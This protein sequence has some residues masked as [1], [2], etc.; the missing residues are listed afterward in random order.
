MIEDENYL[1][2]EE[3][4]YEMMLQ[5]E[6]NQINEEDMIAIRGSEDRTYSPFVTEENKAS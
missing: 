3:R 5:Q 4:S 6:D 2:E 1:D